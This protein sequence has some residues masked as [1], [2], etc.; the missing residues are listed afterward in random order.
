FSL[1]ARHTTGRSSDPGAPYRNAAERLCRVFR[2]QAR[3]VVRRRGGPSGIGPNEGC[4]RLRKAARSGDPK[5]FAKTV[6]T[7]E[8]AFYGPILP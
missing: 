3:A 8:R 1:R 4:A 2:V 7:V 6:N 5:V